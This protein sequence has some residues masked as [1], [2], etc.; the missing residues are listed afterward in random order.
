MTTPE[1]LI[2]VEDAAT[3]AFPD[4]A[5]GLLA[6]VR[7]WLWFAAAREPQPSDEV[8]AAVVSDESYVLCAW[9]SR[10]GPFARVVIAADARKRGPVSWRSARWQYHSVGGRDPRACLC[11]ACAILTHAI[12]TATLPD[13]ERVLADLSRALAGTE[14]GDRARGELGRRAA[15]AKPPVRER[16]RHCDLCTTHSPEGCVGRGSL[17][18]CGTCLGSAHAAAVEIAKSEITGNAGEDGE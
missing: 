4:R 1:L 9:C 10:G 8:E 17:F 16:G 11:G 2:A 7:R 14:D 6:V 3:A 12:A 18:L 13:P 15:A 5:A